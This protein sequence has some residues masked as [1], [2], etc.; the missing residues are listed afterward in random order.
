MGGNGNDAGILVMHG[1]PIQEFAIGGQELWIDR[2]CE[3]KDDLNGDSTGGG[4]SSM[5]MIVR[6]NGGEVSFGEQCGPDVCSQLR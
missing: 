3:L 6:E 5:S 4:V 1:Q 2:I